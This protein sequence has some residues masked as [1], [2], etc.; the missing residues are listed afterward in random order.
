MNCGGVLRRQE[1][2]RFSAEAGLAE[3]IYRMA[4]AIKARPS[5]YLTT[6]PVYHPDLRAL[7]LLSPDSFTARVLVDYVKMLNT[8]SHSL[9]KTKYA[10]TMYYVHYT[11]YIALHRPMHIYTSQRFC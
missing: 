11:K 6:T 3:K 8:V 4:V 5:T 7:N 2:S 9:R 10:I 1:C